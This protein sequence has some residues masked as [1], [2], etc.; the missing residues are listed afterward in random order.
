MGL[1]IWIIVS[2]SR[3][4]RK[5]KY[6][7]FIINHIFSVLLF[8]AFYFVHT[9]NYLNSWR[10]LWVATYLWA[11]AVF[12]RWCQSSLASRYFVHM[13][14]SVEL[15]LNAVKGE[16][17]DIIR[18]AINTPIKWKPGQHIFLR[19]P[20]L[21]PLQSHPF[22][23]L[24]LP[25]PDKNRESQVVCVAK[26]L[27]GNTLTLRNHIQEQITKKKDIECVASSSTTKNPTRE[28]SS[29]KVIEAGLIPAIIDGPYGADCSIVSSYH[30]VLFVVGGLGVTFALPAMMSLCNQNSIT[31]SVRLV[32]SIK[33]IGE[34]AA[35]DSVFHV[36]T[37][38]ITFFPF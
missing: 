14:A 15:T 16:E 20:T 37:L 26:V 32:W 19:F 34:G 4:A 24:T 7:F 9:N 11:A 18:I 21:A 5:W 25:H 28:T 38:T 3:F 22:S 23:I 29:T 6:E 12:I 35:A 31:R 2:G 33:T 1:L 13:K 30:N 36:I 8:L 17:R 27:K 10:Y